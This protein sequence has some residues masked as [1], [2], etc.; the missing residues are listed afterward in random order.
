MTTEET[1]L[2][3]LTVSLVLL[4]LMVMAVL[5]IVFQTVKRVKKAMAEIQELTHRG[6]SAAEAMAP[7]SAVILSTF[8]IMRVLF[9][10]KRK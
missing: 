1:L 7:F 8:Q 6:T 10:K 5:I 2:T 9:K 3:I 4:I